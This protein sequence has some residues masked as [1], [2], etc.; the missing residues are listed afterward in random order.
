MNKDIKLNNYQNLWYIDLLK[1]LGFGKVVPL[2]GA[3]T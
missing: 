1:V 3:L 2:L